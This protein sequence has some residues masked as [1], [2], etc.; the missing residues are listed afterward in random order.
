M[1]FKK[2][3]T[4]VHVYPCCALKTAFLYVFFI[5]AISFY[6]QYNIILCFLD[7]EDFEPPVPVPVAT[8]IVS[9]KW[10]GED[11]DEPVK[12]NIT[13]LPTW[14]FICCSVYNLPKFSPISNLTNPLSDLNFSV[15]F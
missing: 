6:I 7:A 5:Q 12:V 4:F 11:E 14:L 13:A 1:F 8:A 9:D 15:H 3:N 10:E 2:I